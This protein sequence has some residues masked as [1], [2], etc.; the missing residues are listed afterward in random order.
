MAKRET[1]RVA[2]LFCRRGRLRRYLCGA[3]QR[4][5]SEPPGGYSGV[6][7]DLY[8]SGGGCVY[9]KLLLVGAGSFYRT[10]AYSGGGEAGKYLLYL[11]GIG[12]GGISFA[13]GTFLF[14]E[15]SGQ[16]DDGF[17]GVNICYDS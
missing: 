4:R 1:L 6:A 2:V 12:G 17:A 10:G 14:L 9:G 16:N 11:A 7:G 15:R 13:A 3:V 5:G 8:C